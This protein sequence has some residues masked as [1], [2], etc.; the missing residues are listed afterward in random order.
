MYER[1][2]NTADIVNTFKIALNDR[3]ESKFNH[4]VFLSNEPYH[5]GDVRPIEEMMQQFAQNQIEFTFANFIDIQKTN[6]DTILKNSYDRNRSIS[7]PMSNIK[8][9]NSRI[10]RRETSIN[11]QQAVP[12][13]RRHFIFM[14]DDSGSMGGQPWQDLMNAYNGFLDTKIREN[15]S[16]LVSVLTYNNN[17]IIH[18]QAVDVGSARRFNV[19]FRSGGTVFHV[20]FTT[21]EPLILKA[22]DAIPIMVFM[23]DGED[24]NPSK[25]E[26]LV[27]L[28]QTS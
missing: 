15:S 28:W 4:V 22:C 9:V 19:P 7:S 12:S 24:R 16:D 23:S 13:K 14:L 26:I 6:F 21:A 8:L 11:V 18:L 10:E 20:A 1:P 2:L 17:A 5:N 3:R 27:Q 25:I